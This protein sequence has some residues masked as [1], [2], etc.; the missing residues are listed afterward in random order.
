MIN[1]LR[2]WRKQSGISQTQLGRKIGVDQA[3]VSYFENGDRE[4]TAECW[5]LIGNAL[6]IPVDKLF[7]PPPIVF[8]GTQDSIVE[9]VTSIPV[10]G[11]ENGKSKKARRPQGFGRVTFLTPSQAKVGVQIQKTIKISDEEWDGVRVW[12]ELP[13]EDDPDAVRET[14]IEAVKYCTDFVNEE[15]G[16]ITQEYINQFNQAQVGKVEEVESGE[17]AAVLENS[18]G[19]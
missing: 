16:R 2:F 1:S 9:R 18:Q 17:I 7:G 6:S 15:I 10:P 14:K 11:E 5:E 3:M 12:V 19:S 13:C 4:P 8:G